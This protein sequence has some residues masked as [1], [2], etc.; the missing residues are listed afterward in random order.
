MNSLAA[1]PEGVWA[2]AATGMLGGVDLLARSDLRRTLGARPGGTNSIR[3][4]LAEGILWIS[5]GMTGRLRCM[6]PSTGKTRTWV[7]RVGTPPDSYGSGNVV[8]EGSA[9]YAGTNN[10]RLVRI[11]PGPACS[12]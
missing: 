2:A 10:G 11:D 8:A 6:D 7:P 1:T 9:I 5:D 12:A 4:D 3:V